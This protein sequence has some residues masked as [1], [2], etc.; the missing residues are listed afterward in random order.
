M[1]PCEK[2]LRF[3]QGRR[4]LN[5]GHTADVEQTKPIRQ[6]T[7]S[8]LC[9]RCSV[10]SSA[11]LAQAKQALS[12]SPLGIADATA[13]FWS[14]EFCNQFVRPAFATAD[15]FERPRA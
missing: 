4:R 8:R 10:L 15:E 12:F 6:L 9:R 11:H 2:R 1:T 13:A 5:F 7:S 14:N 3:W